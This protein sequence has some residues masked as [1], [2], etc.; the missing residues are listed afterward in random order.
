MTAAGGLPAAGGA[1]SARYDAAN[2]VEGC[3]S[4][5]RGEL[6]LTPASWGGVVRSRVVWYLWPYGL[7]L[8]AWVAAL[9]V[10]SGARGG[11]GD[12]LT[13]LVVGMPLALVVGVGYQWWHSARVGASLCRIEVP[14]ELASEWGLSPQPSYERALANFV[15]VP[16]DGHGLQVW[17]DETRISLRDHEVEQLGLVCSRGGR[18]GRGWL[19]IAG[20]EWPIA[21]SGKLRP[22][23]A[24]GLLFEPCAPVHPDDE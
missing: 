23:S 16:G 11:F 12:T 10:R 5:R 6:T 19:C 2:C 20:V 15:L 17:S 9:L 7:L 13:A 22:K 18:I 4:L 24:S 1:G 8:F 3:D 14:T 21:A